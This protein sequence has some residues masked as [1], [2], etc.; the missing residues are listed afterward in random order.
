[1]NP[2]SSVKNRALIAVALLTAISCHSA[3]ALAQGTVDDRP[4]TWGVVAGLENFTGAFAGGLY[5]GLVLGA[6]AHLPLAVP[7][8]ALRTDINLHVFDSYHEICNLS[9][10]GTCAHQFD[11]GF[12]VS[13]ALGLI[14]RLNDPSVRWSPYLLGGVAAYLNDGQHFSYLGTGHFGLEGGLGF[15]YRSSKRTYFVEMRYLWMPPGGVVPVTV[16]MRF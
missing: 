7:R 10:P 9:F 15:D 6:L 11:P 5:P 12:V 2:A 4:N 13:G 14:A 8:L 16:G 1:L 3:V